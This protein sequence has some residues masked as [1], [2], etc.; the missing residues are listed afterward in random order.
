MMPTVR[1]VSDPLKNARLYF[2]L[3]PLLPDKIAFEG[4]Q[5][6]ILSEIL[7][8]TR[9]WSENTQ[10][11]GSLLLYRAYHRNLRSGI[12][13]LRGKQLIF[14]PGSSMDM[15]VQRGEIVPKE[16]FSDPFTDMFRL[17]DDL[18]I[19]NIELN[20]QD[21]WN[22]FDDFHYVA[23]N[24]VIQPFHIT[25][26]FK[27]EHSLADIVNATNA[28]M[29]ELGKNARWGATERS[30]E[31]S[32]KEENSR[33]GSYLYDSEKA[34]EI[35]GKKIAHLTEK[36]RKGIP[37]D[38]SDKELLFRLFKTGEGIEAAT[39]KS[40]DKLIQSHCYFN[41]YITAL[42]YKTI[43]DELGITEPVFYS[44][45]SNA[46]ALIF[47]KLELMGVKLDKWAKGGVMKNAHL[48]Q[49]AESDPRAL[50]FLKQRL[51]LFFEDKLE[52]EETKPEILQSPRI[53][54]YSED[55]PIKKRPGL[56]IYCDRLRC[57]FV[58]RC[59]Y[60]KEKEKTGDK[61]EK[62]IKNC[63]YGYAQ[64][65]FTKADVAELK[66]E[67][68]L[69]K[70]VDELYEELRFQDVQIRYYDI[71]QKK[72]VTR[73][74]N[75]F[76]LLAEDATSEGYTIA[77]IMLDQEILESSFDEEIK[78]LKRGQ[79]LSTSWVKFSS[80]MKIEPLNVLELA[81][82]NS[83]NKISAEEA[84]RF[85]VRGSEFGSK[86]HIGRLISKMK[87]DMFN[88]PYLNFYSVVGSARHKLSNQRPWV[89]YL[90][91]KDLHV[92]Q[93][94]EQLVLGDISGRKVKGHGDGFFEM[95]GR[96][97]KYLLVQDYKRAKKGA[98]EKPAYI[99]QLVQYATAV[100]QMTGREYDGVILC[101]TK[102]FFH[103]EPGGE[104]WPEYSLFFIPKGGEDEVT[105][106]ET[107]YDEEK[108]KLLKNQKI[109]GVSNIVENNVAI[110]QRLLHDPRFFWEYCSF[111]ASCGLCHNK[112]TIPQFR[113]CF[114][115]EICDI[116]KEKVR[117]N[118][119]LEDYFHLGL[120]IR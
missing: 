27:A 76:D 10:I 94:C 104:S 97:K 117:N 88:V 33:F 75:E 28:E 58:E 86:C 90:G 43:L 69:E 11:T 99:L 16:I 23:V 1:V 73:T 55:V 30:L 102:R 101:L 72:F 98:Y 109:S 118:E 7:E 107:I 8:V 116:V 3:E 114:N 49:M 20:Q 84:A 18:I 37:I 110:Q 25:R 83:N 31:F 54:S 45:N 24:H 9:E 57:K 53:P 35:Y 51:Y 64:N 4:P 81:R 52:Y 13:R 93:Y 61:F 96:G 63:M 68:K 21:G 92:V 47:K 95:T 78:L 66:E 82:N 80:G 40:I 62:K 112:K 71:E 105:L 6:N 5:K 60:E 41:T 46:S 22:C 32:F 56:C 119:P 38:E 19:T 34:K 89:D 59:T 2:A 111:A 120:N 12:S 48:S 36:F 77:D 50:Q 100:Q 29:E 70:T 113:D 85:A 91:K 67:F 106:T 17:T 115:R 26:E 44:R 108:G 42:A 103:G 65:R 39:Q 87:K 79:Y 15:T 14:L 74:V